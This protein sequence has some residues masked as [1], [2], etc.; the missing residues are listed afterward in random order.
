M[1][2]VRWSVDN[3]DITT[4]SPLFSQTITLVDGLTATYQLVLS[5]NISNSVGTFRCEVI[6]GDGRSSSASH[7]INGINSCCLSPPCSSIHVS[8]LTHNNIICNLI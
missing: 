4:D 8:Y 3:A 1:T 6:D 7:A 2:S 5:G